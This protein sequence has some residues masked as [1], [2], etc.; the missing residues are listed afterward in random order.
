MNRLQCASFIIGFALLSSCQKDE[1]A[2]VPKTLFIDE[3]YTEVDVQ[4]VTYSQANNLQMDI[5]QPIGDTASKRPLVVLAHGGGFVGGFRNNPAMV[6][7]GN[8]LAKRGYVAVSFSYRLAPGFLQLFDS[9]FAADVVIKAV[10]DARSA[11]RYMRKSADEGNPFGIDPGQVFIGGNSA[12]AVLA[13]T[14]GFLDSTDAIPPYLETILQANGGFSGNSGNPGY[15]SEV[16]AVFNLA[17]GISRTAWIDAND[18]PSIHFHGVDDDVVPY[19]CGDVFSGF[20]NGADVIDLCG[21]K[22]VHEAA[23]AKGLSSTLNSYPG[24]HVPWMSQTTGET[25]AL[26]E[27]VEQQVYSF[28]FEQL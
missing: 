18:V 19:E 25:N 8:A 1:P 2:P 16:S 17:G 21:S 4:T 12:G 28:L 3:V 14:L 7:M 15:S 6:E 23:I 20:T 22:P 5:Y 27:E 24:K 13:V 9:L 11:V 26:F 10:G